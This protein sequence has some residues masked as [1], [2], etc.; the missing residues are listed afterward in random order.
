M[1]YVVNHVVPTYAY[2]LFSTPLRKMLDFSALLFKPLYTF[3]T[4][5]M[6]LHTPTM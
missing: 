1:A 5:E 2:F 6:D 3:Y 4:L